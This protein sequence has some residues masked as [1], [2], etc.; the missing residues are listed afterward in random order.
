MLHYQWFL[1]NFTISLEIVN[2]VLI[3]FNFLWVK[4]LKI[5]FK[6]S[7]NLKKAMKTKFIF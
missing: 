6:H 5:V 3:F 1:V 7:F 2:A 4:F